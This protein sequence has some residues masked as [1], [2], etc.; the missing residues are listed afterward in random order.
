[1]L[2]G[3]KWHH[4]SGLVIGLMGYSFGVQVFYFLSLVDLFAFQWL[5]WGRFFLWL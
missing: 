4:G 3:D 5:L 1:M 2:T